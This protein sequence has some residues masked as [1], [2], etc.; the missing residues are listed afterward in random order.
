MCATKSKTLK[1]K[2]TNQTNIFELT[3]QIFNEAL[4][5][6]MNVID[7]EFLSLDDWNTKGIVPAVERLTHT[8]K[9][10][11]LPK[12]KE[13][14]QQFYK[15][16]SYFRRAAIASAFGK[17]KSYRSLLRNWIEEK[18][19]AKQEGNRFSKRP[20]FFQLEHNEFPVFYRGNMFKKR[21]NHEAKLKLF[22]KKDW[23]WV[24][25][26]YKPMDLE[27]RGVS[28]WKECNPKLIKSGKKYYLAISYEK[29]IPLNKINIKDQTIISVDLGMTNSAVCSAIRPDGTVIGRT[30]INQPIEK[31]RMDRMSKN[32]KIAQ[33][34]YGY[35]SAPNL[36]RKINGLQK[37][38]V[39]DT[40]RR[41]VNFAEQHRAD[42]I[43]FE[44]L[45][46]MK[47][48]PNTYGAKR[49]KQKLHRWCKNGIQNKVQQMAHYRGIRIRRV[50][51]ANTSKLAY[52]GSGEVVRNHKKDLATFQNGKVYHADLNA[53]YNIGARYFLREHL[54]AFSEKKKLKLEA[55]VPQVLARTQQSLSTFI[56][57]L[58]AVALVV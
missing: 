54:K 16:P 26:T 3:I 22:I 49:L 40:A 47:F 38:I 30:F 12:Y 57:F 45:G 14:N 53:A 34:K 50:N 32:V 31:D 35:I 25:I 17:V 46:E 7:K 11:P 13:F 8:T 58:Q 9:T 36:W 39:I 43:V 23:V 2:I 20:P 6:F 5:Y 27:K 55:K 56:S 52:D 42:V 1:H 21:S 18:E 41:I 48:P 51:A 24:D 15:F 37:Y 10:N 28:G 33:N 4:S 44:F 29:K 19:Q